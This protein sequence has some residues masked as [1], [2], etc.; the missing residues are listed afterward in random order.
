MKKQPAISLLFVIAALYDGL[1]GLLFLFVGATVF[2]WFQVTPPNHFGYV[3]FP[4]ALLI[5]FALMFLTIAKNPS[6]NRN[7]IP[8]GMLLKVSYCSVVFFHWSTGGIPHMWKPFAVF[9]LVFL[10]FFGWAYMSLRESTHSEKSANKP[11]AR[12]G[13]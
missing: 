12:D 7:L 9:D 8:Y 13:K 5:V 3:Q 6:A 4:A 11:D 1:L 2:Q 10:V